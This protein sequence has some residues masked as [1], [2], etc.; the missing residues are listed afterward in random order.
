MT[1]L[2]PAWLLLLPL[3][4]LPLSGKWRRRPV[5]P[6]IPLP[7]T[8]GL[9][10]RR[11]DRRRDALPLVRS[12]TLGTLVLSLAGPMVWWS[13]GKTSPAADLML[14]LDMS[15][16]MAAR[17]LRPDRLSAAKAVLE[18]FIRH[19]PDDRMGLVAFRA[20]TMTACPLTRDHATLLATLAQIRPDDLPEDGTALGDALAVAIGRLS[21]DRDTA[22]AIVLLTDGVAN[23]GRVPPDRAA[24]LAAEAGIIVHTIA[25]GRNGGAPVPVVDATGK[26][27]WAR[28]PDGKIFLTRVDTESLARI[29]KQTGGTSFRAGDTVGLREAYRRI[30]GLVRRKRPSERSPRRPIPLADA[31]ALLAGALLTLDLW[32]RRG[33]GA[34]VASSEL[35]AEVSA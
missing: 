24:R 35:Q 30:A 11:R 5:F 15:G 4:L 13:G 2:A 9:A 14:I 27:T 1:W 22:R 18:D 28:G 3:V 23:I 6:A 21:G 19:H 8:H 25:V 33:P 16:S 17:D 26:T 20:G 10:H 31:C 32:L 34:V 29:A 7:T 12:L